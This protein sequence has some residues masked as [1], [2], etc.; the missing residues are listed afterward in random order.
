M[1]S[2]TIFAYNVGF[3]TAILVMGPSYYFCCKRRDHKERMIEMM[4]KLNAFQHASEMPE[5]TPLDEHPFAKPGTLHPTR[6]YR[7][8]L[9]EKKDW[10]SP[11]PSKDVQDVFQEY[12]RK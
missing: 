5:E 11:D 2:K 7:G 8:L 12:P 9:K 4:M 1:G 3:F 6:E 10:Q